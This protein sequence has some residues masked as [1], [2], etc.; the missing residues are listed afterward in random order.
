MAITA[1]GAFG[2]T[3]EKMLLKTQTGGL[4]SAIVWCALVTDSFA[5]NFDTHDFVA[6]LTNE[7]ANGS[8]YTTGGMVLANNTVT[9]GSPAAG[10]IKFDSDNPA[11]AT[12]TISLAMAAALYFT[13]GNTTTDQLIYLADF[14]TAATSSNGTF[15]V[16]V[17]ATD[18]WF[19]LDYTP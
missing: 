2:L 14:V 6:D 5:P 15:T 4:E 8:G 3:L 13:T 7:I 16:T 1:S 12:S 18:G 19:Y 9:V 11:W 10:Q 17:D